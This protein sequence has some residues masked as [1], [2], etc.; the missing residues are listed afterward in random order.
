MAE[1]TPIADD[2][3]HPLNSKTVTIGTLLTALAWIADNSAAIQGLLPAD[4]FRYI[5]LYGPPLFIALRYISTGSIS[6]VTPFKLPFVAPK[7]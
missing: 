4:L 5:A 2:A 6:F 3:K 7:Q 1:Q